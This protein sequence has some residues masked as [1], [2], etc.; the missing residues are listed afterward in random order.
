MSSYNVIPVSATE[1]DLRNALNNTV[2]SKPNLIVVSSGTP[3]NPITITLNIAALNIPNRNANGVVI[4]ASAAYG[5]IING[6]NKFIGFTT[7]G[8]TVKIGGVIIENCI[9]SGIREFSQNSYTY[10]DDAV[11]RRQVRRIKHRRKNV[12]RDG[13]QRQLCCFSVQ[14]R[15]RYQHQ[16]NASFIN[17]RFLTQEAP[18]KPIPLSVH[19]RNVAGSGTSLQPPPSSPP[20]P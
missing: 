17:R 14:F 4:A 18:A 2:T 16:A 6:N 19:N 3:G 1:V 8:G 5:L 20:S 7:N 13:S 10:L 11:A 9:N 15:T 12:R